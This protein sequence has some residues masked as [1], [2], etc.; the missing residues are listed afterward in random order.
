MTERIAS[1][2]SFLPTV[3]RRTFLRGAASTLV[4]A[5]VGSA[6]E[7]LAASGTPEIRE[8]R[9]LGRTELRIS[10]ISYGS[11]RTADPD[12]VRHALARGINYF[13]TAE[14]YKSGASE[15]SIGVALAERREDVILASKTKCDAD[16]RRADLMHALEAS[17]RRLRTD[18]IDVYF[19]HAVNAVSRLQNDE[20]G[21]FAADAKKQGK[22]RFTG[23][24]GHGGRLVECIDFA[25]ENDL[26]DVLLVGYNFGQDPAFY[27][28]FIRSFDFV[29]PQTGLPEALDR[30]RKKDIGVIAMKT[31]R[32]ARLNDMRP[33]EFGGATTAQAA[34]RWTLGGG[35]VDALIVSMTNA[36][37]I[38]EYV[39]ASGG[40]TPAA[41]ELDW[42]DRVLASAP[43]GY[44]EHGCDR[45]ASS[46]PEGV[47]ISEVLRTR[48]YARDYEDLDLAREDYAKL[49]ANA[50]PCLECSAP[51]AQSCPAGIDIGRVNRAT[52]RQ[53]A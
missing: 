25:V 52:H 50:S 2:S 17:L 13:D 22:I 32:G 47:A 51:C 42:L 24:S 49:D 35:H 15:E 31:L 45:C 30:A 29:A 14:S 5:S 10:D 28:R 38:D 16:S 7:P 33:Y 27:Q 20:W 44:C 12:V 41:A 23:M 26:V 40:A 9:R 8:R 46:C 11:S 19:N 36:E 43:E 3:D 48:M 18:R 1:D 21:E 4:A 53:L 39:A 37:Q 34:F 6:S